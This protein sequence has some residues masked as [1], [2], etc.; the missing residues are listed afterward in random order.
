MDWLHTIFGE[1]KDLNSLQ[2][3]CRAVGCFFITLA[4]IRI[5][6]VRTFGRKTAFDNVITI[7]LGSIFSRVIVGASPFIPTALACLAFVL[8]HLAL[9][10]ITVRSDLIGRLV[11][12]EKS[13]LYADGRKEE[14]NMRKAMISEKDLVESVR[15]RINSDDLEQVREIIIERNGEVSVIR[16]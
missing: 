15:L 7:M 12:G 9:G 13:V 5:A 6:G 16:K 3:V 8:V 4:L 14:K 11:K 10:W 2:M 1:G